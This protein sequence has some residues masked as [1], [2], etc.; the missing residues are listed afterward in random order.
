MNTPPPPRT[1]LKNEKLSTIFK[2]F[3]VQGRYLPKR[4]SFGVSLP[5]LLFLLI[6]FILS[7]N[8]TNNNE[9][10]VSTPLSFKNSKTRTIASL[11][12]GVLHNT[13]TSTI[14][15]ISFTISSGTGNIVLAPA[16]TLASNDSTS[17]QLNLSSGDTLLVSYQLGGL[18]YSDYYVPDTSTPEPKMRVDENGHLWE[19]R[20]LVWHM[21]F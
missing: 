16:T 6:P 14:T 8:A 18:S 10:P 20:W 9:S 12:S 5:A 7:C 21:V 3:F 4:H 1:F 19:R 11:V 13:G 15:N 17:Y 2:A